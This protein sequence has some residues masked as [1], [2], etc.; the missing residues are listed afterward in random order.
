MDWSR[1]GW[2]CGDG[3]WIVLLGA[4]LLVVGLLL[5]FWWR[6]RVAERM[7]DPALVRRLLETRSLPR[8]IVKAVLV[9]LA[10]VLLLVAALRPKYGMRDYV[11]TNTGIDVAV[12]LDASQ[13]MLVRDV[14]PDRFT[15][16]KREIV[17]M[18]RGLKG[19][20]V[21]LV[22][23]YFI[24]Y[25]QAPL[26]SDFEALEIYLR[27][28]RIQDI[29]D[30][31][32]RGTSIGRALSTA[33]K[34]L[35]REDLEA[36]AQA[37]EEASGAAGDDPDVQSFEG[38]RHKAIVIFTDGEEQE[39]IPEDLIA[40]AKEAGIR[41][42]A[43]GV[44]TKT[45]QAVP[46]VTDDGEVTGILKERGDQPVFSGVNME[47]LQSLADATGGQ[48]FPFARRPVADELVAAID[49][50]EKKEFEA[51]LAE[52]G[53]DRFQFLL[54]PALL[55]LAAEAFLSDRRRRRRTSEEEEEGS[56]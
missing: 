34:L 41:I 52:L 55:L 11:A 17:K 50:L 49:G 12:L 48:T 19:G 56:S 25:V 33:V 53:Q 46:S 37:D 20:R 44:G 40:A 51:R 8:Q 26:T 32:M 23:F 24:P 31:E 36:E 38:S 43:V 16:S 3:W 18:L 28:L 7:G 6:W 29:A 10:A 21:A 9:V 30:P 45:G 22:P 35:R 14:A 2:G 5:L 4:G 47:L 54:L 27:D 13:S 39:S 15:A 42:F 1:L